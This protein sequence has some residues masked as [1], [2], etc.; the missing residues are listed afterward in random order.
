[1]AFRCKGLDGIRRTIQWMKINKAFVPVITV[2]NQ[3][4]YPYRPLTCDEGETLKLHII[5]L[6]LNPN[7]VPK[8]FYIL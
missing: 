2:C 5:L 6:L 1:M 3:N 4:L 7:L 8:H